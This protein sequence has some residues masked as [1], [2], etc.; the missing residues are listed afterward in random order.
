MSHRP[1]RRKRRS[2]VN[3]AGGLIEFAIEAMV[4]AVL[5]LVALL[6][7]VAFLALV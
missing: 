3:L 1:A 2:F 7:A 5:A 6:L 4:V